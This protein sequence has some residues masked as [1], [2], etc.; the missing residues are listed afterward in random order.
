M[1]LRISFFVV[2]VI[3]AINSSPPYL[4]TKSFA[5]MAFL[6]NLAKFVISWSPTACPYVSFARFRLFKSNITNPIGSV[7]YS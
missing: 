6:N 2:C 1:I 4:P 5:G 7:I 3:I